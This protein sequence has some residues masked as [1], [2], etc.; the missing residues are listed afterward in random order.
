MKLRDAPSYEHM[1]V[2]L[3]ALPRLTFILHSTPH[4]FKLDTI[5][6][7]FFKNAKAGFLNTA[8]S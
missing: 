1:P 8:A 7:D 2:V 5:L 3:L 6:F 4:L